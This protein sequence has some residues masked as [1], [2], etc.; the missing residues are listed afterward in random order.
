[1][2]LKPSELVAF[3]ENASHETV[4]WNKLIKFQ[5][6]GCEVVHNG[7]YRSLVS[8][9]ELND[10]IATCLLSE[11]PLVSTPI[12]DCSG[13]Q[14]ST[15]EFEE[16]GG[17]LLVEHVTLA[18]AITSA[19]PDI[20]NLVLS[21]LCTGLVPD[22]SRGHRCW[23]LRFVMV[24]SVV[25]SIVAL[26]HTSTLWYDKVDDA[27]NGGYQA[28]LAWAEKLFLVLI[29]IPTNTHAVSQLSTVTPRYEEACVRNV[30]TI[31][32]RRVGYAIF[33]GASA[34]NHSCDPNTAFRYCFSEAQG[35]S[36]LQL[37]RGGLRIE[38]R[39]ISNE[40]LQAGQEL[41][42]SYG[43]LKGRMTLTQRRNVLSS[44]YLFLCRCLSCGTEQEDERGSKSGGKDTRKRE[45]GQQNILSDLQS[46]VSVLSEEYLLL[47]PEAW[48]LFEQRLYFLVR[49]I[50]A[51]VYN[52]RISSSLLG[53]T[54]RLFRSRSL[55]SPYL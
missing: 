26:I 45:Q 42:V 48:S 32:Q 22:D 6:N 15:L 29:R 23:P 20:G 51:C 49:M 31:S 14:S 3:L 1:M 5:T 25:S 4:I 52:S 24:A 9:Q 53:S 2:A 7:T 18:L 11:E 55:L 46:R 21:E 43:P 27:C 47:R 19:E 40:P 10:D 37:L 36:P 44:Q 17:P 41:C 13:Y 12:A 50:L 34:V 54:S 35:T 28:T 16:V 39:Y 8:S 38:L 30:S 33:V